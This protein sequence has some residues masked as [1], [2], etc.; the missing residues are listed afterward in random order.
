MI[1]PVLEICLQNTYPSMEWR[2]SRLRP[3]Q[4]SG[5]PFGGKSEVIDTGGED[6]CLAER[7]RTFKPKVTRSLEP[8][9][10]VLRWSSDHCNEFPG[11]NHSDRPFETTAFKFTPGEENQYLQL[12]SD[13][14]VHLHVIVSVSFSVHLLGEM[15]IKIHIQARLEKQVWLIEKFLCNFDTTC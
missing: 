15:K 5:S 2:T 13:R 3:E 9:G 4:L 10:K 8:A 1:L 11:L 6:S 14:N 12:K 7:R